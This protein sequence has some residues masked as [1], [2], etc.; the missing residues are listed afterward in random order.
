MKRG[1]AGVLIFTLIICIVGGAMIYEFTVKNDIEYV[2][3][4]E[5][6][7]IGRY[8]AAA[9]M[10]ADMGAFR[11]AREQLGRFTYPVTAV[12]DGNG[13]RVECSYT[14]NR[15]G[16]ETGRKTSSSDGS[17]GSIVKEY[18]DDDRLI[19]LKNENLYK[20]GRTDITEY[21]YDSIG[22][23][24]KTVYE[25][26]GTVE[27]VTIKTDYEYNSDNLLRHLRSAKRTNGV[28]TGADELYCYYEDGRCISKV[29]YII[30][31]SGEKTESSNILYKYDKLGRLIEKDVTEYSDGFKNRETTQYRY[32][33]GRNIKSITL[34]VRSGSDGTVT[35]SQFLYKYKADR[36]VLIIADTDGK[37]DKYEYTYDK[38]GNIASYTYTVANGTVKRQSYEYMVAGYDMPIPPPESP[39]PEPDREIGVQLPSL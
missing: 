26:T 29:I 38:Y 36:P 31:A 14:Y 8:T 10:F 4:K 7:E 21:S 3:A 34:T 5:L 35:K 2:K 11:D 12:E 6:I 1:L 13:Y 23:I 19:Y 28:Y 9:D 18:D 30:T 33:K 25:R 22:R 32:G 20:P 39:V 37:E 16:Y 17:S 27:S 24:K 15:D